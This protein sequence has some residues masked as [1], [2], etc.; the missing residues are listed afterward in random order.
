MLAAKDATNVFDTVI[1]R[2]YGDAY[3]ESEKY[4]K[5][6]RGVLAAYLPH[7]E[8]GVDLVE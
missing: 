4:Q 6:L 2:V 8:S 3:R 7:L 1:S 5:Y